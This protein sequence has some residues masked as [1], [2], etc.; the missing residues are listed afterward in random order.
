MDFDTVEE[1]IDSMEELHSK[2]LEMT[3]P[4]LEEALWD[5]GHNRLS[6]HSV[7]DRVS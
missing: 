7:Y 4:D 2:P 3:F 6:D 1:A 5:S